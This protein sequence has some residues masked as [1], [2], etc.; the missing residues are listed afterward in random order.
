[1]SLQLGG[2]GH[3]AQG[4]G[5]AS[6]VCSQKGVG[7]STCS[8]ALSFS[9]FSFLEVLR[10]WPASWGLLWGLNLGHLG[11]GHMRGAEA[12]DPCGLCAELRLG[13]LRWPGAEAVA[14]S[15]GR[16][17]R[18]G[19]TGREGAGVLQGPGSPGKGKDSV[20]VEP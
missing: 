17:E 13:H 16:A 20:Q 10:A 15:L 14:P 11:V 2:G 7:D 12:F 6:P 19:R 9:P 4:R 1:M 8:P 3:C 5:A 18:S